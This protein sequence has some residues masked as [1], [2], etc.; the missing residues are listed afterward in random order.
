MRRKHCEI[1]ERLEVMQLHLAEPSNFTHLATLDTADPD[2]AN[3]DTDVVARKRA[4]T[5]RRGAMIVVGRLK[6]ESTTFGLD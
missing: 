1:C 3:A 6:S 4:A 5:V 2:G